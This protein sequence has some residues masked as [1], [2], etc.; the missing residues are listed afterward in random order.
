MFTRLRLINQNT[1]YESAIRV[2]PEEILQKGIAM[3]GTYFLQYKP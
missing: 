3:T 1:N 2:Y